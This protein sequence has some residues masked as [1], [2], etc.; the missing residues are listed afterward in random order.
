[1]AR[2]TDNNRKKYGRNLTRKTGIFAKLETTPGTAETGIDRSNGVVC[3]SVDA[4]PLEAETVE[5]EILRPY[6]GAFSEITTRSTTALTITVDFMGGGRKGASGDDD[7]NVPADPQI[8]VLLQACGMDKTYN[9][10][11]G[12]LDMV[13]TDNAIR[14]IRYRTGDPN[15]AKTCTIVYKQDN[16][17][18]TIAGA[19]GTFSLNF[20]QNELPSIE[21]TFIGKY[22]RPYL[23]TSAI[24]GT[25]PDSTKIV[26]IPFNSR[27]STACGDIFLADNAPFLDCVHNLTVD[28]GNV[29]SIREC[30]NKGNDCIP[31]GSGLEIIMTDRQST[32]SIEIDAAVF[33]E[34]GATEIMYPDIW[35]IAGSGK[36]FESSAKIDASPYRPKGGLITHGYDVVNKVW[37]PGNTILVGAP[38]VT[39]GPPSQGEIETIATYSSDLRFL[40]KVGNDDLDIHFLG[41]AP[42]G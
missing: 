18:Q 38:Q 14:G 35:S 5:R 27:Y 2:V 23:T 10:G 13:A 21:F 4:T 26:P 3:R 31:D 30:V 39:I 41:G 12:A 37:T 22:Q 8:D 6:V 19:R 7:F 20:A 25:F 33:T 15:D 32:G 11:T 29:N 1:M 40:P 24:T 17:I 28:V 36:P 42:G 9:D 34:K 16:I